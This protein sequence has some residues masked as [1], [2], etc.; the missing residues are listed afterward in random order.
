LYKLLRDGTTVV[1][2]NVYKDLVYVI[3]A[4]GACRVYGGKASR[5]RSPELDDPT[6]V[7]LF[8]ACA[9][10]NAREPHGHEAK[11]AIFTSPNECSFRP[12][13]SRGALRLSV[14]S[15]TRAE[16]D[17]RRPW[18][19][20]VKDESYEEKIRVCGCGSIRL[21]LGLSQEVAVGMVGHAI[22]S[23][24]VQDLL[25][26][27]QRVERSPGSGALGPHT[28]FATSL[29]PGADKTSIESYRPSKMSWN[30]ASSFIMQKFI[31]KHKD[32]ATLFAQRAAAVFQST[33]GLEVT[34]GMFFEQVAPLVLAKGG[35][36]RVRQLTSDGAVE[37]VLWP[38]MSDNRPV[39]VTQPSQVHERCKD[40]NALYSILKTLAGIDSFKPPNQYFNFTTREDH[41]I[42]MSAAVTICSHAQSMSDKAELYFVVPPH[43]FESGWTKPQSF[44]APKGQ[45]NMAKLLEPGDQEARRKLEVTMEQV[46]VVNRH[47]VQYALS[48]DFK[49][50][51]PVT[52]RKTNKS[53]GKRNA[54]VK[55]PRGGRGAGGEQVR[56]FSTCTGHYPRPSGVTGRAMFGVLKFFL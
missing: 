28:L 43:R 56:R 15:Y 32:E 1:Y 54:K 17:K 33:P 7:H 45:C 37:E 11:L 20:E 26:V 16:M 55:E 31:D 47:L 2:E 4:S 19:P 40:I 44:S 14:P 48:M 39:G 30:V 24:T 50:Q 23:L 42:N 52:T 3:P 5:L 6:V 29:H 46:D 12:F 41:P 22:N 35:T 51:F 49:D 27:V 34:A 25:N 36:F 18:F 38:E 53:V 8:D 9:G 21:V 13:F 10:T